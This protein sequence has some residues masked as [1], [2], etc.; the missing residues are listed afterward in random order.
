MRVALKIAYEGRA[1]FGHQR[2]PDVRT[3]EGECIAALRSAK[4]I[5]D[6]AHARFRSASRTDRGVSALGNVIAFDTTLVGDAALGA[7]NGK[8]RDV[9]AWA[10]AEVPDTFNPRH[11]VERWYRY[12]LFE[13]LPEER[14]REA[15][16]LFVGLHDL[17]WFSP[18][19]PETP[20]PIGRV[21][22]SREGSRMVVDV[23]ARS[24][25]RNLVRRIVSAMCRYAR[26][27]VRIE[28]I[29]AALEGVRHDFGTVPPDPL[30]LM[31]IRYDVAFRVRLKPKVLQEWAAMRDELELRTRFLE[32]L[33]DAV[34]RMPAVSP[35]PSD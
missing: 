14:L 10:V 15:A 35:N 13:S 30:F 16:R 3:V 20:L 23:R 33:E 4:V 5:E 7:F 21:D 31:E 18:D 32:G 11:A 22:V 19:R 1:F 27:E 12:H 25:R 6:A 34:R 9:W 8:A 17:R 24:F 2:Q 28:D 29:A 26:D